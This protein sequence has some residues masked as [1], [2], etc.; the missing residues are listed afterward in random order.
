MTN[1]PTT[2]LPSSS[3]QSRGL[4][5]DQMADA[6]QDSGYAT[7][8]S[9]PDLAPTVLNQITDLAEFDKPVDDA[10]L[11][12]FNQVHTQV[13]EPLLKYIRRKLKLPRRKYRP[14]ALRL[15]I[16]GRSEDDA[17][18]YIVVLCPK[19]QS[20]R[21]KKFFDKTSVRKIC[22]PDDDTSP[23]FEVLVVG[24]PP[25]PKASDDV[26]VLIRIAGETEGYTAETYCGAPIIV[27]QPWGAERRCTLG[28]II[29]T[30]SSDGGVKMYGLTVGHVLLDNSED[31]VTL[32]TTSDEA[33][34]SDDW[35][36][37][38]SE[39]E[40]EDEDDY[41]SE[42]HP[43]E[44]LGMVEKLQLASVDGIN[45][46]ESG[47]SFKKAKIGCISRDYPPV[48]TDSKEVGTKPFYD[49][50]LI[51]MCN[52]KSNLLRQRNFG[53]REV[54]KDGAFRSGEL[55]VPETLPVNS[56]T[57]QSI[58]LMSGSEGP[59]RGSLS[60]LPSRLLLGPGEEFVDTLILSLDGD[61]RV[62]DG[63]SG[64]WVVDSR[65][66]EVHGY[67]VAADA[68]G[69]GY[70]IPMTQ[71][72]QNIK[73]TLGVQSVGL[74]TTLD[75]AN[76]KLTQ[77]GACDGLNLQDP[78]PGGSEAALDIHLSLTSGVSD[79]R[80]LI[81]DKDLSDADFKAADGEGCTS[82]QKRPPGDNEKQGKG[83]KRRRRNRNKSDGHRF[84][85][86]EDKFECP[87]FKHEPVRYQECKGLQMPRFSD[88]TQHL[89]RGH[90]LN[91]ADVYCSR[92]RM[93]FHGPGK[94]ERLDRHRRE[95]A[96][97]ERNP[98]ARQKFCPEG[99]I[100]NT[101][102]ILPTEY[103]RIEEAIPGSHV[104]E[105]WNKVWE[106]CFGL[107]PPPSP[108]IET[109]TSRHRW[110]ESTLPS[111]LGANSNHIQPDV[112][113]IT[114][115]LF[116]DS[117]TQQGSPTPLSYPLPETTTY[118]AMDSDNPAPGLFN[119]PSPSFIS[120]FPSFSFHHSPNPWNNHSNTSQLLDN[121]PS[122]S[123]IN[124]TMKANLSCLTPPDE[125]DQHDARREGLLDES[126]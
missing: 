104:V 68:F 53:S 15:M 21:I 58:F 29:K 121:D 114:D 10:T 19:Q 125:P 51:D 112:S 60:A 97:L 77:L 123:D 72:F 116:P 71:A 18:P 98:D 30:V 93:E 55:T 28:G 47:A 91:N 106:G 120:N 96:E 86:P 52:F 62:V 24:W 99:T 61:K 105:K 75:M 82:G 22:Q 80:A 122:S 41:A 27:R 33:E 101:G 49:W 14:I 8:S 31:D 65:T 48:T 85:K 9:S 124:P 103:D 46:C 2:V 54:L 64:S 36:L 67:L 26:D 109:V 108:Y 39:S 74:A 59:K 5:K 113:D 73:D 92:C 111:V 7:Q 88:I 95:S 43:D 12:R 3:C 76:L 4:L 17:K 63:D 117:A 89:K 37:E 11:A 110:A 84:P 70:V 107:P 35:R 56:G 66:L 13:E 83:R 118:P 115:H 57:R 32:D 1:N 16:L 25:E 100:K 50:A 102:L 78:L 79:S 6:G 81:S 69:E 20:K 90:L 42:D 34:L 126:T 119:D 45:R 44:D 87:F 94:H 23:S 40:S 38:L